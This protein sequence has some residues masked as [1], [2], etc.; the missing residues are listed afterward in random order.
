[1]FRMGCPVA[2]RAV[3]QAAAP[4]PNHRARV[5]LLSEEDVTVHHVLPSNSSSLG[6]YP[7]ELV[8]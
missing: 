8:K 5:R 6:T 1:M 7:K 4:G 3:H 2:C